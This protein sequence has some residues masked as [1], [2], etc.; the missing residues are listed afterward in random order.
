[1]VSV[2]KRTY[3]LAACLFVVGCRA[4]SPDSARIEI[5]NEIKSEIALEL[6][7]RFNSSKFSEVDDA[8][9]KICSSAT[10]CPT[11][12][13]LTSKEKGNDSRFLI[14]EQ[15]QTKLPR[16]LVVCACEVPK[17]LRLRLT[18]SEYVNFVSARTPDSTVHYPHY[19]LYF[20]DQDSQLHEFPRDVLLSRESLLATING[21]L[22][23]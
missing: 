10:P 19:S 11:C 14:I 5:C 1:M 8:I 13:L 15:A 16:F 22:S 17:G 6:R 20:V 7:T 12:K 23:E 21:L 9:E 3:L 18:P 4:N 2:D